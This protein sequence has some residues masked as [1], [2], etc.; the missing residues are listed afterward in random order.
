MT[1]AEGEP[2]VE[3]RPKPITSHYNLF[4]KQ[5]TTALG[6]IASFKLVKLA[7]IETHV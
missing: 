4:D 5:M 6:G 1:V 7:A 2:G 3:S